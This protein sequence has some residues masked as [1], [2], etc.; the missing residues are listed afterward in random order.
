M[1]SETPPSR[2]T[3]TTRALSSG[4]SPAEAWVRLSITK[5]PPKATPASTASTSR[6][7]GSRRA[8]RP[9]RRPVGSSRLTRATA[10]TATAMPTRAGIDRCSPMAT[11]TATGRAAPNR[12]A[13]GAITLM[14]PVDRAR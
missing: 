5:K 9:G 4:H 8:G 13:T 7:A 1:S 6:V 3:E 14:V 11:P 10:A 12:A 2:A